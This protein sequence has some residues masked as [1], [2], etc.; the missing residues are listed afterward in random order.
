M[1]S[2]R[3]YHRLTHYRFFKKNDKGFTL[4]EMMVAMAI[5]ITITGVILN[6]QT[7]FNK[8]LTLANTAYD[9]ALTLRSAQTYG[10]SSR[11]MSS[12]IGVGYGL[13]FEKGSP[14]SF[15]FFSDTDPVNASNCHGVPPSGLNA[16]DAKRGN[17]VYDPNPL[18]GEK[19]TDYNLGN[20]ITIT[21]FCALSAPSTWDCTYAHD[22]A[23][24]GLTSLDIVFVRPDPGP[25]VYINRET[26]ATGKRTKACL[27][28]SSSSGGSSRVVSISPSGAITANDSS[29]PTP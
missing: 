13:H 20:T 7:T 26:D 22:G 12:L 19:I 3:S 8:T 6:S 28:V 27:A 9:I 2:L 10:V 4:I 21:D 17:C 14:A 1:E 15:T 5:I 18:P 25:F 24:G 11:G 16:P 23:T 29:C